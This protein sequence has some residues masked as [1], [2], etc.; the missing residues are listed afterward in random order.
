MHLRTLCEDITHDEDC[1]KVT[2]GVGALKFCIFVAV[3]AFFDVGLALIDIYLTTVHWY[4]VVLGSQSMGGF[5]LGGGCVSSTSLYDVPVAN[6]TTD[7]G[8]PDQWME[9]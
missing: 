1:R 9:L 6:P 2:S 4:V 5:A 8:C 7:A 3:W